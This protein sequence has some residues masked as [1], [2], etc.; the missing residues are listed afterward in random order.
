MLRLTNGLVV[1]EEEAFYGYVDIH[2]HGA[3]GYDNLVSRDFKIKY[4]W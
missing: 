4:T 2:T 3:G 1:T